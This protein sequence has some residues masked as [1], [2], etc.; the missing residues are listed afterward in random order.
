M[1]NLP[2]YRDLARLLPFTALVM[3]GIRAVS[4]CHRTGRATISAFITWWGPVTSLEPI[5]TSLPLNVV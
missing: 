4:Q 2:I 1:V 5:A 3:S